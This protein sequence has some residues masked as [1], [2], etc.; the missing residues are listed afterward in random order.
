MYAR[1]F[2]CLLGYLQATRRQTA[3]ASMECSGRGSC[4]YATGECRCDGNFGGGACEK[5]YCAGDGSGDDCNGHGR[6]L[7]MWRLAEEAQTPDGSFLPHSFHLEL[8]L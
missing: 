7:P 4:D 1:V 6:C 8:S 3:H 2:A 5:L